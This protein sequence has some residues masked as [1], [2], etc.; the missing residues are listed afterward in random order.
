MISS[1]ATVTVC[2]GT[3]NIL[4]CLNYFITDRERCSE[5][6]ACWTRQG[7]KTRLDFKSLVQAVSSFAQYQIRGCV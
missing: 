7:D 2:W 3:F 6:A 1:S 4:A 5:C